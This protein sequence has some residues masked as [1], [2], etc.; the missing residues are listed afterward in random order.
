MTPD[1]R[2]L[3]DY[4]VAEQ[5]E[6]RFASYMEMSRH[7]GCKSKSGVDRLLKGLKR[8]GLITRIKGVHRG[9]RVVSL[10]GRDPE[11][12]RACAKVALDIIADHERFPNCRIAA[13]S[14][15]STIARE[16]YRRAGMEPP[17]MPDPGPPLNQPTGLTMMVV[18]I[19]GAPV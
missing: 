13:Y 4:L 2:K 6:G 3:Y 5:A 19:E 1:M 8:R 14:V 18:E 17:P 10:P 11:T 7:V 16:I 9:V 15:A 12:V